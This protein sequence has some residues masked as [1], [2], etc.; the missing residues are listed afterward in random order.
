MYQIA[1]TYNFNKKAQMKLNEMIKSALDP[2][3]IL[4][5]GKNGFWPAT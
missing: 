4:A 3:G 2:D 5:I 1:E